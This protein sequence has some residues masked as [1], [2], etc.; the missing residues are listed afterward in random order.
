MAKATKTSIGISEAAEGPFELIGNLIGEINLP[1][2]S[3]SVDKP[4][5]NDA[6][7]PE[8]MIGDAE[9][10]D[11][12]VTV[13]YR[14]YATSMALRA[15]GGKVRYIK[16][17]L[18]DGAFWIY[19]AAIKS[20]GHAT[21]AEKGACVGKLGI[22]HSALVDHGGPVTTEIFEG[23]FALVAGAGAIDLTDL[24]ADNIDG[25]GK[26]VEGIR[27]VA[28]ASNAA[29]VT[30]TK[31]EANGYALAGAGTSITLAPGQALE[32]D[33]NGAAPVIGAA[34]KAL[35]LAGAGTDALT[36]RVTMQ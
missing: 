8:L 19:E 28:P 12:D 15:N 1:E 34:A 24:G 29:A 33:G 4:Q 26:R 7:K 25:T 16:Y 6:V 11:V 9:T 32:L 5:P 13:M 21:G 3:W 20:F 30:I 10:G 36:I 35:T 14:N 27:I 23:N 22:A 31:A 17:S 2:E 18:D